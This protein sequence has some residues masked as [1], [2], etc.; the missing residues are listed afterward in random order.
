MRFS[1]SFPSHGLQRALQFSVQPPSLLVEHRVKEACVRGE[2]EFCVQEGCGTGRGGL[3]QASWGVV[4]PASFG[5]FSSL[6]AGGK[7]LHLKL[8]VTGWF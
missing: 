6:Q 2:G 8:L 7:V 5:H 4:E 1:E 3:A